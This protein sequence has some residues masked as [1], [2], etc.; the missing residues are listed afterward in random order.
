VI[1]R[2]SAV[3]AERHSQRRPGS[4][5]VGELSMIRATLPCLPCE[6]DVSGENTEGRPGEQPSVVKH[7]SL[8]KSA[9]FRG[10]ARA[11]AIRAGIHIYELVQ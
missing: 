8:R 9:D 4:A 3:N 11:V 6:S 1:P 2:R 5:G 10:P 7:M